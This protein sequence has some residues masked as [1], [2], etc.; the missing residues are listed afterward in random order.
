[1][2]GVTGLEAQEV[3]ASRPGALTPPSELLLM[4]TFTF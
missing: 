2:E 3:N 1:M 4:R